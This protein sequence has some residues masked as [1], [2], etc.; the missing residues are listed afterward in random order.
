M[1]DRSLL[2]TSINPPTI[3]DGTR[4]PSRVPLTRAMLAILQQYKIRKEIG[5]QKM[6]ETNKERMMQRVW[7]LSMALAVL[8]LFAVRCPYAAEEGKKPRT[9]RLF[10][11][12]P[13]ERVFPKLKRPMS[14]VD[15][16]VKKA[17][18]GTE[19]R[20]AYTS[21]IIRAK[22]ARRE[23][24]LDS[25]E[26]ALARMMEDGFT[27][28]AVLSLHVIP[29]IEFHDLYTNAQLFSPNGGRY[30]TGSGG[31]AAALLP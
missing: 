18:P 23:S 14:Q 16:T 27:H 19:I 7:F 6:I 30:R 28:V 31:A 25:P 9:K 3:R 20:W 24:T 11:S 5:R 26:M 15:E 10:S 2:N 4:A 13:S 21:K 29:G 17:F 1:R 22:L 12:L 8:S